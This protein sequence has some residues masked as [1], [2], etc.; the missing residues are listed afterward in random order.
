MISRMTRIGKTWRGFHPR[1]PRQNPLSRLG[2]RR[3]CVSAFICDASIHSSPN[4]SV[5][6]RQFH[7]H[8]ASAAARSASAGEA[9][10]QGALGPSSG[11]RRRC[12]SQRFGG[13]ASH[14][15][16]PAL[17]HTVRGLLHVSFEVLFFAIPF[18]LAWLAS[19]ANRDDLL[20]RWRPGYWVLPLGALYS[21]AI[22]LTYRHVAPSA[23]DFT[24][25]STTLLPRRR[26]NPLP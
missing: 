19:R 9:R 10:F 25:A 5:D 12:R 15:D 3:L 7:S 16:G 20:L 1:H 13:A 6:V 2:H 8:F 14:G 11:A 17:T 22:R 4:P 21:I 26:G 23:L 24:L 18:G